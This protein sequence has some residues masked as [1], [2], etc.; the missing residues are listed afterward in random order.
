MPFEPCIE[1]AEESSGSMLRI[2]GAAK[3]AW[4]PRLLHSNLARSVR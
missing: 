1:H 4:F 2:E 3:R